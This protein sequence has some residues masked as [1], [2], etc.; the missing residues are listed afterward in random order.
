M[1]ILHHRSAGPV[2]TVAGLVLGLAAGST[3]GSV[4]GPGSIAAGFAGPT[5]SLE[6]RG[7]TAWGVH[8]LVSSHVRG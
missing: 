3:M 7:S 4:T 1:R 2:L 6:A 5:A 8:R